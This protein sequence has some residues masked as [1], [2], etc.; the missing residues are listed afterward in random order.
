[1][2]QKD[3][4]LPFGDAFSP[5]SLIKDGEVQLPLV[6]E[7][8]KKHEG[9]VDAFTEEIAD[10]FYPDSPNPETYAKNVPLALGAGDKDGYELVTDDFYFTEVGE[11]LYNIR[12]DEDELYDRLAQHILLNLHGRK[13]VDIIDDLKLGGEATTTHNIARELRRQYGIY[14]KESST[15]WNQMRGW[16]AQADLINTNTHHI[17]LDHE[18]IDQ[19]IGLDTEDR[20]SLDGLSPAQR[21]FLLTLA[22]IDPDDPIRNNKVRELAEDTYDDI[23][24]DS[25]STTSQI[26]DP[27]TE[28]GFIEYEHT[29]DNPSKPSEV[30]LTSKAEADVLEP[31]LEDAQERTGVPRAVL[32]QSFDEIR[33]DM[34]SDM[35][36]LKG[37]ALEAFAIRI[38]LMLNLEFEDWRVR[39]VETGG[40]EVDVVMDQTGISLNRWQIQCKNTKESDQDIRTKH[41]AKEVGISRMVQSNTIL[42]FT[43]ADVVP[44]ARQY[45]RQVMQK[46]NLVILFLTGDDLD[47]LDDDPDHLSRTLKRQVN[48][49]RELKAIS[50]D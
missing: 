27:L 21:A 5:G 29:A 1:M 38:G 44:D 7:L 23:Y 46:E 25:K 15:H 50:D 32:R 3:T 22:R 49:I 48:R 47:Q 10:I 16:M 17:K 40:A 39:G 28:A 42:M 2:A 14:M 20:L 41:V 43:R 34:E 8:V 19:L 13:C 45:A 11:E 36:Y 26:L 9:D 37:R 33:R 35:N 4:D 30:W 12:N 24:F 18:K 6:L 31:L